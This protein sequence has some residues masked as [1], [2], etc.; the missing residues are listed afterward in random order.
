MLNRISWS[1]D[2]FVNY[3]L[4]KQNEGKVDLK[5]VGIT[6][7][8]RQIISPVVSAYIMPL[9]Y[10]NPISTVAMFYTDITG[11]VPSGTDLPQILANIDPNNV[12]RDIVDYT[13][14]ADYEYMADLISAFHV[15]YGNYPSVDINMLFEQQWKNTLIENRALGLK[16]YIESELSS[17]YIS[18][19]GMIPNDSAFFFGRLEGINLSNRTTFV[20]RHYRNKYGVDASLIQ[21]LQGAK[22][23]WDFAG[24]ITAANNYPMNRL[25][26]VDFIYNM[27][28]EPTEKVGLLSKSITYL[29][30]MSSLR[31]IYLDKAKQYAQS[32]VSSSQEASQKA[33]EII[34][35]NGSTRSKVLE[36][37][38]DDPTFKRRFNLLWEDSDKIEGL[39]F[40]KHEDWFGHF[41]DEKYPWIYHVDLGWLYS[42]GTSQK[43][44]WLYSQSMGWFWT[45]REIF[46]E[47]PNLTA[48][49]Q[50]FIFR[51]RP[52]SAS[53]WEGS[54]SLVTLPEQGSASN[55]IQL[56]DYGYNPF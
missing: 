30:G 11:E 28:T 51:V 46:K 18:K 34:Q 4:F 3:K 6:M 12:I 8:G 29:N 2:W 20:Q 44:V 25:A 36:V 31:S 24:G 48:E 35:S 22:K 9:S 55:A 15:L 37:I 26:A 27:A 23:M 43:N 45:N 10:S 38:V 5:V 42:N 33:E 53:G 13:S 49:N 41:M 56:Y 50:R 52:R 40:W 1:F 54:W 14:G 19:Y 32:K 39:V 7:E 16:A 21:S 17:H 47:H